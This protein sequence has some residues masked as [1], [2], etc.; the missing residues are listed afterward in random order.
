MIRRVWSEL[1]IMGADFFILSAAFT[2]AII[3]LSAIAGELLPFYPVSFEVLFPF[4]AA[5]AVG[6]WGKTRADSNYDLIAAQSS[7]LFRW[8][9][10]RDRKSVV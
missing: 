4:Y 7:S 5:V 10:L 2:A 6:E 1:K 3:L 8:V 9:L